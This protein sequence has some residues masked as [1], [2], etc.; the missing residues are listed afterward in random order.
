MLR[1]PPVPRSLLANRPA[2]PGALAAA[3]RRDHHLVT[4]RRP[5]RH[6]RH[7]R[8]S[9]GSPRAC[10]T[11]RQDAAAPAVEKDSQDAVGPA[12]RAPS[13]T[14]S[15]TVAGRPTLEAV[16]QN[17]RGH[18]RMSTSPSCRRRPGHRPCCS[19]PGR[20]PRSPPA[21]QPRRCS[22]RGLR[23]PA[24][25]RSTRRRRRAA[26]VPRVRP[27]ARSRTGA[28]LQLYYFFPLDAE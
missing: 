19:R 14:L 11:P 1:P 26:A 23:Q 2:G 17:L 9:P 21:L 8:Q 13:R 24:A 28:Q 22:R 18:A 4:L 16:L 20:H 15:D 25:R 12:Q 10:S 7:P 5:G 27:P 3:A 6:V